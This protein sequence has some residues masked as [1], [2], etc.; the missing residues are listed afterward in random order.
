[1]LLIYKRFFKYPQLLWITLLISL[2]T[3]RFCLPYKAFG[4]FDAIL[5]KT[6]KLN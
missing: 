5:G 4:H 3:G 1:M 6:D 2:K